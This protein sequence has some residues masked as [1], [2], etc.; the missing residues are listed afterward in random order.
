MA[1]FAWAVG[2][3]LLLALL[4]YEWFSSRREL[5]RA[6]ARR[7]PDALAA[8][9]AEDDDRTPVPGVLASHPPR[10]ERQQVLHPGAREPL[11]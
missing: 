4:F 5:R 6:A 3:A 7:A 10:A 1:H 2:D 11:E 8:A 9:H